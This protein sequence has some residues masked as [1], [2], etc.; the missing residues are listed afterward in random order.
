MYFLY[1]TDPH[2]LLPFDGEA[3]YCPGF[4][5]REQADRLLGAILSSAAWR[6]DPI[7]L[8]GKWVNQPRMTAWY[9]D[10]GA[11]YRYSGL[12]MNP[13]PWT[14][15]LSEI[16]ARIE[17]IAPG[18]FNGVLLNL[19]RDGQDGM[20]WHSDDEPEL[21]EYPLIASVSLGATRRFQ[22]R[23]KENKTNRLQLELEHGSLLLMRGTTQRHWQHQIPKTKRDVGQRINLTYRTIVKSSSRPGGP[24][25]LR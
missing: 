20:A 16:K 3:F 2:N 8:Y 17:S 13:L 14:E 21:G 25:T 10:S 5:E 7:R 1:D 11:S 12:T 23:N 18:G 15:E 24:K 19:Y 22:F 6:Q 9:G 4:L